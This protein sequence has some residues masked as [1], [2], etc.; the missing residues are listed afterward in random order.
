M[1]FAP[2][3]VDIPFRMVRT[4]FLFS[5]KFNHGTFINILQISLFLPDYLLDRQKLKNLNP[6][7]LGIYTHNGPFNTLLLKL[8]IQHHPSQNIAL[9]HW[10][11][12]LGQH[13]RVKGGTGKVG[14]SWAAL[15]GSLHARILVSS[16]D[17]CMYS[18]CSRGT[19]FIIYKCMYIRYTRLVAGISNLSQLF[20]FVIKI[21]IHEFSKHALYHFGV[22]ILLWSGF[23]TW[24]NRF[25]ASAFD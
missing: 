2:Q 4:N 19:L 12:F 24:L 6:I 18:G 16:E 5:K 17:N 7:K 9:L 23:S 1:P 21:L 8:P 22:L 25:S 14:A 13:L 10:G 20:A 15:V 3:T 11:H